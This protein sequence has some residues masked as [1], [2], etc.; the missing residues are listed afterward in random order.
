MVPRLMAAAL[1]A[2]GASGIGCAD[3]ALTCVTVDLTCAPLY[4]PTWANVSAT[5]LGPKCA[6]SGCHTT[7]AAKGG[8][9]LDDPATAYERLINGGYVVAGDV[10]CSELTER[11]F[12]KE[13]SL[14]M[15]RGAPLSD[16]EACAVAQW[17]AA[18]APGPVTP[19][20]ASEAP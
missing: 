18:G 9:I 16:A 2:L 12:T 17:V 1:A 13:S 15:P 4:A 7:A 8:L 20:T 19:A 3:P 11:I 14:R 5:T 10:A 6:A